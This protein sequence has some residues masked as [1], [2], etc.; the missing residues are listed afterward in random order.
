MFSVGKSNSR[1]ICASALELRLAVAISRCDQFGG[2]DERRS[3]QIQM[4]ELRGLQRFY[5]GLAG[6]RY[7]I[8]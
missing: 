5:V 2:E 3:V 7:T 6:K 4:A 8:S 1:L